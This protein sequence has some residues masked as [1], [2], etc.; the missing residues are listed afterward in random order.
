V[1]L[2]AGFLSA[3]EF[4]ANFRAVQISLLKS[5]IHQAVVTAA[6]VNAEGS[7]SISADLAELVELEEYERILVG[8]MANGERF[9]TCVIYGLRGVGAIELNGTAA[10]L[11][12][13]GD[14][15]TIM[16]FG[17]FDPEEAR[18]HQPKVIVLDETN[19]VFRHK[20]N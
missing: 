14:R 6:N 17:L 10:H 11:G 8:N 13:P 2:A 12:K 5:K 1:L 7:L 4:Q 9:E 20:T 19:K 16:S 18:T 3:Y 15:L